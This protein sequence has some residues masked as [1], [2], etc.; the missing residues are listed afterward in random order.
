MTAL[1]QATGSERHWWS[2]LSH[3]GLLIAPARVEEYF[4]DTLEPLPPKLEERLRRDVTRAREDENHLGALLDTVF[5]DLLGLGVMLKETS[6]DKRWSHKLL[7]G[8]SYRPNRLWLGQSGDV[9][10]LF[11]VRARGAAMPR[12]GVGQGRREVSKVTEWLRLADQ[13]VGLLTNGR[14]FRLIHAG[15]DYDAWCEWDT[16]FWFEE[17]RPGLQVEALRQLLCLD[18]LKAPAKGEHSKLVEAIL[19]SRRGQAQLSAALGER[20]RLAVETLIRASAQALDPLLTGKKPQATPSDVYIAATRIVMR[21]VVVLFA[22]ARELLPRSNPLYHGSYGLQGL[23][24]ELDRAAGGRAERLRTRSSAWL[25]LLG[26]FRL[27]AEGSGHEELPIPAYGGG[28]FEAGKAD[29]PS[30]AVSRALAAF[31]SAE[32]VI[33]DDTIR[34]LLEYLTRSPVKVR[35]GRISTT[36]MQP[37]DFSDLSSEY[38]G[39]LYEGLLDFELRRVPEGDTF[40]FLNV[41][42]EPALPMSR[43]EKMDEK[44]L[45]S[46]FEK[47]K[48]KPSADEEENV[49]EESDDEGET[50]APQA[51]EPD[52]DNGIEASDAESDSQLEA[53]RRVSKWAK[54]AVVAAGLVKAPKG[55]EPD[56]AEVDSAQKKLVRRVL[57]SGEW[58]LV[59]WGGMRKGAGT[60]YTR[61]QLAGPTTRRTLQPLAYDVLKE[62]KDERTGLMEPVEWAPKKP[63]EILALKVCDP[64]MGS[65]SFLISALRFL[66]QT[67]MESLFHHGRL[68]AK[69]N[70]RAICRLADGAVAGHPKEEL[71][72]VPTD[73]PEFEDRLRARLKRHVVE[74][75]I[76]GVDLDPVAVELARLALWIETMDQNLP[77]EFLGHKLKIGNALVGC[78]FDRFQDYPLAAWEREGGDKS[79]DRFVHHYREE[80]VTRGKN[81]GQVEKK[82]D[83][84][85]HAIA[86]FSSDKI[87]PDLVKQ[88]RS[89]VQP[90]FN[91]GQEKSSATVVHDNA[92]KALEQ[93]R[94]LAVH[95]TE[96]R[97]ELYT[98]R[99]RDNEALKQL[100]RQLDA[101]CAVW[102]WPGDRIAEAPLP[103]NLHTLPETTATL[104]DELAREHRFFHWELEF[105]DVFTREGSGFDAIVGNPPWDIQKPNSKEFF[106]NYDPLYRTYGKQEALREQENLFKDHPH[107]EL[108]WTSYQAVFKARSNWVKHAGRPFGDPAEAEDRKSLSLTRG[109]DNAQLHSTWR[110]LRR[111]HKGYAD[112]AHPYLHQGSA[113]LNTYKMFLE[114][115]HALLRVGGQLG[116]IVPNGLYTDKGSTHLR[117]LFLNKCRWQWLFGFEN[118]EGI[119]DIDSRFKFAP[120]IVQKGG[121][122]KAIRAAFMRRQLE[123]WEAPQEHALA[124]PRER[125]EQFSPKSRAILELSSQ[126]DLEV[127]RKLYSNGVLLGQ[128]GPGGWGIKYST[129][130]HMTNDSKLFPPRPRWEE[131]GYIPD[132]YGNWLKGKWK[133]YHGPQLILERKQGLV[134]SRDGRQALSVEEIEDVALPLYEGRMINQFDF[135]EKGW[136]S[137]KGRSAQWRDLPFENKLLEPQFLMAHGD[138]LG[139]HDREGN[140]KAHRALKLGFMDVS[141]ATNSRT[142]I[143]STTFDCPHGNKVPVLSLREQ[144]ERSPLELDAVLNSFVFDFAV[145]ARL[146]GL[147][148]NWFIVEETAL[149]RSMSQQV[150]AAL[151]TAALALNC[152]ATRFAPAWLEAQHQH[153]I[154]SQPWRTHWA[155]TRYERMRVRCIAEALVAY[156]F[157]L[158]VD[159][160]AWIL[161]ETA[162]SQG[163]DGSK[164]SP[165]GFWRV[166]REQPAELR[167]PVLAY[168]AY[169]DLSRV[170]IDDFLKGAGW[171]PPTQVRLDELSALGCKDSQEVRVAERLG[172]RLLDWQM[173]P[174]SE[175]WREC[176]AHAQTLRTILKLE[177]DK[178]RRATLTQTS[179]QGSLFGT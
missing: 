157:G 110:Q 115:A 11:V 20:V 150:C 74:A 57:A 139:A 83:K 7:T 73:H 173:Q 27:V 131:K 89:Q 112:P 32:N 67:L 103:S 76:Y 6:V 37:V 148:L 86:Q 168:I 128:E 97:A 51:E 45:K 72:P 105:P 179:I 149:P 90:G 18:A 8:E 122:T 166:D 163:A 58:F 95:E 118:R 178:P 152:T 87:Y 85:T 119:F 59:R 29:D 143:A 31:E 81:K 132:E 172:A 162:L 64:A 48:A 43:L 61:P 111:K 135:S 36:V 109:T 91:F 23:R 108:A 92:R 114:M 100:R 88:L 63:E 60:F 65:G 138:F 16:D 156:T 28:L 53:K 80:A 35:Q 147:T 69:G 13:K 161:R 26:L 170:G 160:F 154:R 62:A 15:A 176:E 94:G 17:G 107:I 54:E 137:G 123:D 38:I 93:M 42:D 46:L 47:L 167:F 142:M 12:L 77:F 55:K 177:T 82:G 104:V 41:G 141:S 68:E 151:R 101:W 159:D 44:A 4:G 56:A 117:D 140:T 124:Y 121:Q 120:I 102:F 130:F 144:V 3:G 33:T 175:S 116:F 96:R 49:E 52:A 30:D 22:E 1:A 50:T 66:S 169:R 145:R 164:L 113:D 21:L 155:I 19:A 125:V 134:L 171:Q 99:I 165:K 127:L 79:H 9:F 106:S 5:S 40:V 75:C 133:E 126:Q 174:T 14:Q 2:S 24:E 39:I 34:T 71:L 10:P 98:T 153:D 136:V 78:W 25:R 70:D 146:G 84:W 129:E 158:T